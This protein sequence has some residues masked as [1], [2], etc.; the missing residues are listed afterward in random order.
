ATATPGMPSEWG[1]RV[2]FFAMGIPGVAVALL[3]L[4]TL[5]EPPR[6]LVEGVV[7]AEPA[8]SLM[9]VVRFLLDKP[10]YVH[11]LVGTTVAGF[12][13]NAVANFVLPFY[14]RGFDVSL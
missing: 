10:T 3:V 9:M 5:R 14:L 1:W 12:T 2:A 13:F 7:K 11:L 8:P 6:G 4:L